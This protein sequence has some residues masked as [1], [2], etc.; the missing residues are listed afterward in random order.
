MIKRFVILSLVVLIAMISGAHADE[1]PATPAAEQV[2]AD[3]E[4]LP[5]GVSIVGEKQP[6]PSNSEELEQFVG[7]GGFIPTGGVAYRWRFSYMYGGQ[8]H[9][10]WR[11]PLRYWNRFGRPLFGSNCRF[12]RPW[13][14][15]FYC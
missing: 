3:T 7:G 5:P 12:G 4:Q 9:Y 1:N 2:P 10:G 8:L 11:Y 14:G 13:G 15:F 6:V